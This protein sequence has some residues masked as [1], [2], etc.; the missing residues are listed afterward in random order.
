MAEPLSRIAAL[1]RAVRG[2]AW[3]KIA[4]FVEKA[5]VRKVHLEVTVDQLPVVTYGSGI[6]DVSSQVNVSYDDGDIFGRSNDFIPSRHI[7]PDK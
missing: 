4:V 7:V 5:V 3:P 2:M 6:G 1:S